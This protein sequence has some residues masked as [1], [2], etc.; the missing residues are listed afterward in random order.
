MDTSPAGRSGDPPD[1]QRRLMRLLWLSVA[2]A[3]ATISLKTGAWL[4]TGSVGLLS[5]ALESVVNLVAALVALAA[6]R[7]AAK[8]A[9]EEHAYG[10]TKAE[11]FSAGAEG[12]MIF[13][14]AIA[15]GVTA[16]D[17][18]LTPQP[19]QDVGLGLAVST[20]ASVINLSVGLLLVRA[21]RRY[22]SI[23]LEADGKHLMTDVWTS[24]GVI[25][26]VAAVAATGWQRL[27]PIIAIVVAAN[28]IYTGTGLIRRSAGGLM[29]R[30]L[31]AADRKLIG[32]ALATFERDGIVFHALRTRQSGRR[33]FISFHI[34]VPGDW[35]V[36]HGHDLAEDVED[37]IRGSLPQA[38]VFTHVEPLDDPRSYQD[39]GLDRQPGATAWDPSTGSPGTTARTT[40]R[41]TG[42]E[43]TT[44]ADPD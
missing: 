30:A 41:E 7:W 43:S 4:L 27:D 33:A 11:Y 31:P 32:A 28:I 29:D 3:V 8:P 44:E 1:T 15:I 6:L 23:T 12:M 18:L 26:G 34:L 19:I 9:D 42:D 13:V 14:A 10:H 16:V 35:T 24:V 25:V 17:R 5:D 22:R 37:A 38:T 40:E 20:G 21:G 2:A 36:Q 39:L